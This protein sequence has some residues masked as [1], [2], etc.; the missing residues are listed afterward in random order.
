MT[1]IFGRSPTYSEIKE[2]YT[3]DDILEFID[4]ATAVRK[5]ILSFRDEP[6]VLTQ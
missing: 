2:Y 3:R 5:V 6:S 4:D 1:L